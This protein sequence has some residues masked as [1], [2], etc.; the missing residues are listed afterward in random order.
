MLR[1]VHPDLHIC[2]LSHRSS[3]RCRHES[4]P[5][6]CV[7]HRHRPS[8]ALARRAKHDPSPPTTLPPRARAKPDRTCSASICSA[9]VDY[10]QRDFSWQRPNEVPSVQS[11]IEIPR[12][13]RSWKSRQRARLEADE[14]DAHPRDAVRVRI[15]VRISRQLL[16]LQ[17]ILCSGQHVKVHRQTLHISLLL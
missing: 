4:Y 14:S 16:L 5:E 9:C 8:D 11:V 2:V 13:H 3:S 6:W 17:L 1:L 10:F 12:I 15:R 7:H